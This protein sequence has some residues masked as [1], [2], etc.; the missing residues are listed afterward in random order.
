MQL[1]GAQVLL[2]FMQVKKK[3]RNKKT[4]RKEKRDHEVEQI[5]YFV[6]IKNKQLNGY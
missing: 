1:D 3:R 2:A 6:S 4:R 5:N